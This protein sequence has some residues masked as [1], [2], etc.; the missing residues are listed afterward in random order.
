MAGKY[1][2]IYERLCYEPDTELPP[3]PYPTEALYT[4]EGMSYIEIVG[5]V[6]S[7]DKGEQLP[8]WRSFEGAERREMARA[9][10]VTEPQA[11]AELASQGA[12]ELDALRTKAKRIGVQLRIDGPRSELLSVATALYAAAE[13]DGGTVESAVA[14]ARRL[15]EAVDAEL[16]PRPARGS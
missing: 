14:D 5:L 2:L 13:P 1:D 4:L 6:R 10:G 9:L 16:A 11:N 12:K 3:S 8:D 7:L 15:I